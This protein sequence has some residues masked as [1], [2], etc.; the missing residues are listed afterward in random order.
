VHSAR[1][2]LRQLRSAQ[3]LLAARLPVSAPPQLP[4]AAVHSIF[5]V[6]KSE[7]RNQVHYGA[8]IDDA[9]RPLGTNPVYAYW[10]MRE[11]GPTSAEALLSHEE[12]AYGVHPQQVVSRTSRGGAV[13]VQLRAW[14]ERPLNIELFRNAAGCAARALLDTAR[15][16]IVLQSIYIEIGFLFA[17]KSAMV[18]GVRA[19]DGRA[20][21]HILQ[22]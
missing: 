10:R 20:F 8:R 13:R 17:I 15:H 7:N 14:P 18:R 2:E 21:E 3:P 11:R 12:A 16:T 4:L 22:R 9:C 1:A 19:S 5:R 6:E